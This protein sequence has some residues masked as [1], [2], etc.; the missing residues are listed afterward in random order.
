MWQSGAR[1]L[2]A[3]GEFVSVASRATAPARGAGSGPLFPARFE[4]WAAPGHTPGHPQFRASSCVGLGPSWRPHWFGAAPRECGDQGGRPHCSLA[5][6]PPGGL[7]LNLKSSWLVE[8][9]MVKD[10]GK[11][12][13]SRGS[14]G[15]W[16]RFWCSAPRVPRSR[17]PHLE[18]K[19]RLQAP[20]PRGAHVQAPP[21]PRGPPADVGPHLPSEN[22]ETSS[23]VLA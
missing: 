11:L 13:E 8:P 16:S 21:R 20:L 23:S 9:F 6:P 12:R 1:R 4:G 7:T 19:P 22:S 5:C 14:S 2:G 3:E 18:S 10:W 15:P 17:A